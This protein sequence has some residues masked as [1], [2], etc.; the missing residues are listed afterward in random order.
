M[1]KNDISTFFLIMFP[2]PN[3]QPVTEQGSNLRPPGLAPTAQPLSYLFI[4]KDLVG[5]DDVVPPGH[6]AA[7]FL[8]P[9]RTV[10]KRVNFYK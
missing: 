8:R 6:L 5:T 3:H 10:L 9:V 2:I 1:V 7:H 4:F